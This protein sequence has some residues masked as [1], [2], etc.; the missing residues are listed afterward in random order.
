MSC[1]FWNMRRKL[2]KQLAGKAT[3]DKNTADIATV[4]AEEKTKKPT[5]KVGAKNVDKSTSR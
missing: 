3:K 1:S 2:R 4:Q 5:K